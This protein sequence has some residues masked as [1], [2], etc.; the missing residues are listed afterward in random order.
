MSRPL[1]NLY[2]RRADAQGVNYI[3]GEN[4]VNHEKHKSDISWVQFI[5]ALLL[6]PVFV[7]TGILFTIVDLFGANRRAGIIKGSDDLES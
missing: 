5:A 1:S 2:Y 7:I 3:R 4:R 6:I